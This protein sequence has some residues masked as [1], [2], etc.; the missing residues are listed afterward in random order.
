MAL[1]ETLPAEF[2][3]ARAPVSK[4]DVV[5]SMSDVPHLLTAKFEIN[6][7]IYPIIIDTGATIS[8]LPENGAILKDMSVN[9]TP[10]NLNI[11][12]ADHTITHVNKKTTLY[13]K[14]AYS[15]TIPKQ[16][17]FYI[18]NNTDKILG[19]EALIGLNL[20]K[21]F[22]FTISTESGRIEMFHQ[23]KLIGQESPVFT[24]FK[25]SMKVDSRVDNLNLDEDMLAIL[26]KF[27]S[28]F[29]DVGKDCVYGRPMRI[30]TIHSRPIFSKQRHYNPEE[31][32]Q[33]KEHID[34]L[35]SK[36]I[37][38]P[39]ES[40]YAATSR[41]IP[42]KN[43]TG[44][45]V[46]NY[47][48]LNAVTIRDSYS[49]P[50]VSDIFGAI[51]G[52]KYFTTMDCAQGFYQIAVDPRDRHKTAFST[53][54]GNFEFL[55]CPFGARNSCSYF[56]AEMS[57]IFHDGLYTRCVIYVDDILVFGK[58]RIEHDQNLDWV[59]TRCASFNVKIKLEKCSFA[60]TEVEYLGFIIS[61][62][63]IRPMKS[64]VDTLCKQSHPKDKTELRSVIGKL[65]FYS[66]FI[67]NYSKL[68]EP[69]RELF[70]KNK[71][72]QWY[73]NH[74]QAYEKL[75]KALSISPKQF[76]VGHRAEKVIEL[77]VVD[78]SMEAILMGK[79][80]KLLCRTSRLLSDSEANYSIVEKYLLA[81]VTAVNKF[82]CYLDPDRFT[83][84]SPSKDLEKA[85]LLVNRPERIDNLL[86]RMP[87]GFDILK[88]EVKGILNSG[89]KRLISHIP[90]EIYYIDGACRKNGKPE[91]QAS[92]AVCAEFDRELEEVGFVIDNPS[93]NAAEV[94]AAI[95]AC[96]FA[97][98]RGQTEITI[99][100]DSKY[101]HSAA[102]TWIDKWS[103]SDWLDHKKKPVVNTDLFKKLIDS[104]EGLQI[105][106][107]HVK[108]HS[109][110][111]GNIRVD[112]LARGLLESSLEVLNASI[113]FVSNLQQD[114]EV[115]VLKSRVKH[116]QYD[117]FRVIDDILYFIDEKLPVDDCARIFVPE[118]SRSYLLNAAHD[119][120]ML[121]GHHGIKKTF[122]KLI[123]FW[124]P[125]M[126]KDVD[127]YVKSCEICQKFK[128][129][130]GI[131]PGYL[132][133]IP[134]SRVFEHLHLDMVGPMKSTCRGNAYI[135]TATDAFSKWAFAKPSQTIRT[136]D[137]IKFIEENVIAIHGKPEIIITDRGAQ[138]TS[139]EWLK[140][141][142]DNSIEHRLTTP[143]HPQTNGID[144]RFNGT[145]VKI[146]RN[147][148]N[149]DHS[150]W[151]EKL[152]WAL[153]NYNTTVHTSTGF[154][155]YQVL[156]AIEPR[157]PLKTINDKVKSST[158]NRNLQHEIR[159]EVDLRNKESQ[160]LQAKYYD[161]IRKD[162]EF[163]VGDMVKIRE[164][165]V[166]GDLC[167]KFY[168]KWRGPCI[169]ISLLTDDE[170]KR[171][172][173]VKILDLEF[174]IIKTVA[175]RDVQVFKL[176][177]ASNLTNILEANG[178]NA[179]NTTGAYLDTDSQSLIDT[180]D[181]AKT[182][183]LEFMPNSTNNYD[184][185]DECDERRVTIN[186]N[187]EIFE[188]SQAELPESDPADN[189]KSPYLCDFIIDNPTEDPTCDF[190][191]DPLPKSDR[192]LRSATAK[193][194]E[195]LPVSE[196]LIE[197][198]TGQSSD[199]SISSVESF[200]SFE[201]NI[202]SLRDS[203][204]MVDEH[205]VSQNRDTQEGL[206]NDSILN[207][208]EVEEQA[209]KQTHS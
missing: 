174:K 191:F 70:R 100:T 2:K 207:L 153:Y 7:K 75:L 128:S 121:G 152:K 175:L 143:Y 148:V 13:L 79:D 3:L 83:V 197:L 161:K 125:Q 31:I 28:T 33:M 172:K 78:D 62:D 66:R 21:L 129:S 123:R 73:P 204:R 113:P 15:N 140:F 136:N 157:S 138:F 154:S 171:V 12:L 187:V 50:H 87:E 67:P 101:L 168:Q 144:E 34:S 194:Q 199:E 23:H 188:Y 45:L 132:N 205:L 10:A 86:L 151:D 49:I 201:E 32:K 41:M 110:T 149:Q 1:V 109:E 165:S 55:R 117:N 52:N 72:F 18:G 186:D 60:K 56:Q 24:N 30:H 97:K 65:N 120:P 4:Q 111:P 20:L 53:P 200:R 47:I 6:R 122:R 203:I 184:A 135:I 183:E 95:K 142:K 180:E 17:N 14:P 126:H 118:A 77:Q 38:Q 16:A 156:H 137:V 5:G 134:V 114:I 71:D 27:K 130:P 81:L 158:D 179:S 124:W 163:R 119:D 102:T 64:K 189:L 178:T 112:N 42:K 63:S 206:I 127:D 57:R 90:Q 177:D 159:S 173:A 39:T 48:P 104:K 190:D 98:D 69:L 146:L 115:E 162:V 8:F 170:T 167:K 166:P 35:I 131:P 68:L 164:Q 40:G 176:R 99:V 96:E 116:G 89:S 108:G 94:T 19:H 92:W 36:H 107:I 105:E 106:W 202:N 22:D 85:I 82:R 93:N 91:C 44:R 198:D 74:Q 209:P 155:P 59:L 185:K 133:S 150:N 88:F 43:G 29:T 25:A 169:I 145:I 58:T 139:S 51:Q 11:Q 141:V 182:P 46:V 195:D 181:R 54:I 193:K 26:R 76:L 103:N 208:E 61:G 9:I 84:R 192:V 160:S 147:Y 80:E 196:V 37:I